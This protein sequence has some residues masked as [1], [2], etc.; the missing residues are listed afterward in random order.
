MTARSFYTTY[1]ENGLVLIDSE[2]LLME[3][4]TAEF[5]TNDM[6][7]FAD[8]WHAMVSL[9]YGAPERYDDSLA[10]EVIRRNNLFGRSPADNGRWQESRH[11][12]EHY[13][14]ARVWSRE[15]EAWYSMGSTK[16]DH[17]H[18]LV[19]ELDFKIENYEARLDDIAGWR[20]LP[21]T[22]FTGGYR[23]EKDLHTCAFK[24][25]AMLVERIARIEAGHLWR[26]AII[27]N[28]EVVKAGDPDDTAFELTD[29]KAVPDD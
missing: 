27:T 19:E 3:S 1:G 7:L 15:G 25:R 5:D 21:R 16:T 22:A 29:A 4:V 6:L 10:E 12:V 26:P 9:P 18:D 14:G 17:L 20:E 11:I 24:H 28:G 2:G 23:Y 13:V 8:M